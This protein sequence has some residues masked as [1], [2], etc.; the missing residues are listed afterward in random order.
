MISIFSIAIDHAPADPQRV[1]QRTM[2]R[3]E[4]VAA[5]YSQIVD[6][7]LYVD[8]SL[9]ALVNR[10]VDIHRSRHPDKPV[11]IARTFSG[12]SPL[13]ID[14]AVSIS[15]IVDEVISSVFDD[16]RPE[17]G[18]MDTYVVIKPRSTEGLR[19]RLVVGYSG[20]RWCGKGAAH[21]TGGLS[22]IEILTDQVGAQ[23]SYGTRPDG[24]SGTEFI[25]DV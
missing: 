15:L 11:I 21:T 3:M 20:N 18:R 24:H 16:L 17:D 4:A 13:S 25:L 12:E 23:Y 22:L 10:I 1:I 14:R 7:D 5:V 19:Y 8:T 6:E 9:A 2:E